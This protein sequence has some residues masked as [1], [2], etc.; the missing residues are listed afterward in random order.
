MAGFQLDPKVIAKLQGVVVD[1]DVRL[2][3]SGPPAICA[4]DWQFVANRFRQLT[5]F[6]HDGTRRKKMH[7]HCVPVV[8]AEV[9]DACCVPLE[10]RH[11]LSNR[12]GWFGALCSAGV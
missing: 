11:P 6:P 4:E 8:G 3:S 9:R 2:V 7:L 1:V 10:N 12:I 5:A